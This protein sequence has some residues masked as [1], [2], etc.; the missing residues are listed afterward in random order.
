MGCVY[1]F[2]RKECPN[3]PAAE[4]MVDEIGAET[5][6]KVVKVN[7]DNIGIN[8]EYKLLE[9]QIFVFATPV[10][11]LENENGMIM[12]S[13]G[14]VPKYNKLKRAVERL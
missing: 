13:A 6:V 1:V 3:C 7:A 8:L 9:E 11:V 2:K 14:A 12:H 10:I 5:G 4:A